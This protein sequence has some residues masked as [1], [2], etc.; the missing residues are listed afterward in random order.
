[1]NSAA[2]AAGVLFDRVVQRRMRHRFHKGLQAA[3]RGAETRPLGDAGWTWSR[4]SSQGDVSPLTAVTYAVYGA[5][6]MESRGP[7]VWDM[8]KLTE[9]EP[10]P[11]PTNWAEVHGGKHPWPAPGLQPVP[12]GDEAPLSQEQLLALLERDPQRLQ[13][14]LERRRQQARQLDSQR[15]PDWSAPTGSILGPMAHGSRWG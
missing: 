6:T 5:V 7:R 2:A 14:H 11:E 1:M 13:D 12:A 3:V 4:R 9:D 10:E 15:E 8:R